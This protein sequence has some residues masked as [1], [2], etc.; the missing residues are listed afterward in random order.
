MNLLQLVQA[1]PFY[2][3]ESENPHAHINSFKRI[4]STL[5]FRN[6]PNDVIK[7]MMFPYS[8]EGAAKTWTGGP[9]GRGGGRTGEQPG[10]GGGRTGEPDGQG[11]DQGVEANGG[12]DEFPDFPTVIAQQ[13]QDLLPTIIAQTRSREA[14][15]G[16]TWEDFKTLMREEFYPNNEMQKLETE[17]WCHAMVRAGHAAYTDQ[18]HE[19]ARIVPHLVTLENKMIKRNGSLKKNTDKRG[20]DGDLSRDGNVRDDNKRSRTGRA[21]A[22]TTNPIRKEY[23]STAPKCTNCNYHHLPETPCRTCTNYNRFGHFAKDCRV[24]QRMVNL[25]NARNPIA[26]HRACFKCGGTDHYKAA[27]PRLNRAPGQG[28]NCP[29]HVLAVDGCQGRGNNGNQACGRAFMLGAEEALQDPNIMMG[30]FTLNN[31][32]ATTLFDSGAY[33]SIV[34]TTFIHLLD[35]EPSSL[36]E[37]VRHLMSAKV[38]EQKLKDIIVVRNFSESPYRLEPSKME[39]LSSQLRELQD[40]GFIRSSSSL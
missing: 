9:T 2:G 34:S 24:G 17:F 10:R 37:K 14:V 11:G 7:L 39:E 30:T 31:H 19:L 5:R 16:I 1:N 26:A 28:G 29:N 3:R 27:C 23:T 21:F 25:L 12:I 18:F 4:T 36:E 15:V 6:V 40:K 33:Y 22:T 32:Y 38:E 35:T 8:L 13:L 20:N